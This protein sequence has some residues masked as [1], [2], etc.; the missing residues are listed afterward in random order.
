MK[1]EILCVGTELLLGNI[2]NTDARYLAGALAECGISCYRQTVLGDNIGRVSAE[3]KASLER[4]DLLLITGGLGPT[5]DDIT[6]DAVAAAFGLTL[7]TDE[8]S[9]RH[10][11]KYFD[12]IARPMPERN[13]IQAKM[14]AG[15][16]VFENSAGTANAFCVKK[17]GKAVYA[18]PGPPKE[19]TAVFEE[20]LRPRLLRS[21][22]AIVKRQV[23]L[24]GISE[25]EAESRVLHL[26]RDLENPTVGIYA[27]GGEVLLQVTARAADKK[28]A[29][30]MT[31]P[32]VKEICLKADGFVYGID[33]SCMEE[34]V[35]QLLESGGK[36]LALAESCT[37]GLIAKRLTDIAG[38]SRVF[39]L[40]AVTYSNEAKIKL[41]GV[42]RETLLKYGAVSRETALEM[43]RGIRA[44]AGADI[45]LSVTGIAGPGGGSADKPVGTVWVAVCDENGEE[46]ELIKLYRP[47]ADREY[48]RSYSATAALNMVRRR[49]KKEP[50][51]KACI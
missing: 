5:A 7:V 19:L 4:C 12:I 38:A 32:V 6:R 51:E 34:A 31:G 8:K 27:S 35:L 28:T 22:E 9:E 21:G 44:A 46:A 49:L 41:L 25:S 30:E 11:Q 26:T 16:E 15:A 33:F 23:R 3:I 36:T 37:G 10:I 42:R 2:L 1:A 40:G 39:G 43:A 18:L 29:Y 24:F 48:I 47:G 13:L 20:H 45:G 14:P 17:D 50:A